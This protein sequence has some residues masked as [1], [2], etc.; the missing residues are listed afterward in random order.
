MDGIVD[1]YMPDFK[2]ADAH[3]SARHL[4]AKDYPER[5]RAGDPGVRHLV[6]PGAGE[7]AHAIYDWLA[8]E[9]SPETYVNVMAQYRPEGSVLRAPEK[10]PE[11]AQPLSERE[12]EAALE[13][14][15]RAGLRR[16]DVRAPHPKLRRRFLLSV[17]E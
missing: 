9:I 6:M 12:H 10:Y 5:V 13:A 15:R 14:A 8:R 16:I 11:L 7:D 3:L 4:K 2:Y 17:V 1:I